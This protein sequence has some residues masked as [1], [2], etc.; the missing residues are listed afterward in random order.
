MRIL[1]F[2]IFGAIWAQKE[3]TDRTEQ[4]LLIVTVATEATDGFNTVIHRANNH[5]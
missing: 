5:R 2:V 1:P 3:Q 4:N